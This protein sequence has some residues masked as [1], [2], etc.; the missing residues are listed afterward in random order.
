MDKPYFIKL[1]HKY[2]KGES[3]EEEKQFLINYYNLF[4]ASPDM[5]ALVAGEKK[6]E[7][8][9][10]IKENIWK[11]IHAKE[12]AREKRILL[13]RRIIRVTAAAVFISICITAIFFAGGTSQ[14][15]PA[16]ISFHNQQKEN[17]LIHLPDGSTVIVNAGGKLKFPPS[18]RGLEKREVYLEGEAFFD[19]SHYPT[20]PFI[21]HTGTLETTVLG[22]AFNVKALSGDSEIT[23]TVTRG[24]V[25][26]SK[27]DKTLGLITKGQQIIYD[28]SEGNSIQKT[29]N[30]PNTL[31][32]KKQDLFLDD[33]TVEDAAKLL[34]ERF[35]VNI[36]FEEPA[37]KTNRFT[38]VF[39]KNESLEQVLKS[40]C[41]FN[42]V[43]YQYNK[44]KATIIISK[45]SP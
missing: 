8:S 37:I 41:E 36:S 34:A 18:F 2:L 43:S 14:K 20:H 11:N 44:E 23:V 10:G 27:P 5:E 26:I 30:V 38:T 6:E 31:S 12:Q 40:I 42:E 4:E 9:S 45:N 32:W 39:L 3:T 22:T 16:P 17:C 33:V 21:V 19:I 13:N 29:I 1:L 35:D 15:N 24:K 7:I 25:K 28:K